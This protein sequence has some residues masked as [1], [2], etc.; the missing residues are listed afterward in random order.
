M[1]GTYYT[2]CSLNSIDADDSI[3]TRTKM[4]RSEIQLIQEQEEQY[5]R[6][7]NRS[8]A[9]KMAPATRELRLME[10]RAELDKL[11]RR[12]ELLG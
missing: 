3:L 9:D 5:R 7:R 12:G 2:V 11:G 4:L 1:T 6:A 8:Q 10:I